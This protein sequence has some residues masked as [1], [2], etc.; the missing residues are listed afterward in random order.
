MLKIAQTNYFV[1]LVHIVSEKTR[2]IFLRIPK[3]IFCN[4]LISYSIR[5]LLNHQK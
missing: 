5:L 3:S 4:I 1:V 2:A